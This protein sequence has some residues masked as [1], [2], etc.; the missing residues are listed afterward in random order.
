MEFYILSGKFG[1]LPPVYR[2]EWYDQLLVPPEVRDMVNKLTRQ[3][4]ALG[5]THITY[6][7][8]PLAAGSNV[9]PY[10]DAL[11]AACSRASVPLAL[12]EVELGD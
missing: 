12:A 7:T 5:V 8:K 2:I 11:A 4:E 1:L 6:F 9:R 3:I 10:Q